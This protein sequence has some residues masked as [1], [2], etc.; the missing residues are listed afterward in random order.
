MGLI[1]LLF[2]RRRP[3]KLVFSDEYWMVDVGKHVFPVRKYRLIYERLLAMGVRKDDFILPRPAS[4]EDIERVH[5]P[6]YIRK[7]KTGDLSRSELQALELPYSPELLRFARLHVG[8]TVQAAMAALQEGLAV[9]LGGGFHHAF[10]DHGEGFCVLNDI[11]VAAAKLLAEGR[12]R[13]IMIVDGDVHQGNGTAA[14][15]GGREEI[16]TFSIHQ[17]DIYPAEKPAGSL[18]VG[19]WSGDGDARYLAEMNSRFPALYDSFQP[20]LVFFLA[21]TDPLAGDRLGGLAVTKDGLRE[22]DRIVLEGARTRG[23]PVVVLLAGGYGRDIE[24]TVEAH[25]NTIRAARR[26]ARMA[27]AEGRRLREPRP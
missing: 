18:D 15:L 26:A 6:R 22:R 11:A 14:M 24:D 23:V 21:G 16:F 25:V 5:S 27:P 17:M 1:D 2:G 20:D 10:A 9:H 13:R 7:L 3:V 8:G 19:L 4:D 12:V